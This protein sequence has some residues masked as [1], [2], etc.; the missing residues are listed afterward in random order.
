VALAECAFG[1]VPVGVDVELDDDLP[2][3]ALLF[4]EAQGRVVVSCA[5][6]DVDAVLGMAAEHAV[7]AARIG[8]VGAPFGTFAL[9][10]P[11]GTIE[12]PASE[13]AAIYENAIPRRM[14]GTPADVET[15]LESVVQ[16]QAE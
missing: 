2:A 5:E 9:R 1:Q 15:S 3:N 13:L 4:G 8:T 11:A 16:H 7:P 6:G 10:T 12:A 14:E